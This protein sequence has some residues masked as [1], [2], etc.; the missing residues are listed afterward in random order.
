[1]QTSIFGSSRK[2]RSVYSYSPGTSAEKKKTIYNIINYNVVR[3]THYYY[4][5]M[6]R[7]AH[8]VY[9]GCCGPVNIVIIIIIINLCTMYMV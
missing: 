5:P 4:I 8:A 2:H 7:T 3:Q 1:M 9:R 6:W